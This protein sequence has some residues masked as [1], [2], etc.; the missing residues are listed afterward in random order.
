[1]CI[2]FVLITSS[3]MYFAASVS[4]GETS[5]LVTTSGTVRY[6]AYKMKT[7][8]QTF[9]LVAQNNKNWKIL[10]DVIRTTE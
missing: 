9:I 1:M 2:A 4:G 8:S 6:K 5:I 10:S 3:C 7:F